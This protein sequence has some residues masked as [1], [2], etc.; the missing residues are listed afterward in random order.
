MN[1]LRVS[2]GLLLTAPVLVLTECK[3]FG[4]TGALGARRRRDARVDLLPR[5]RRV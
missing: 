3:I 5:G 2:G 4:L 1:G